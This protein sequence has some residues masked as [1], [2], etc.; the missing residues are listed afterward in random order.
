MSK[1]IIGA[2]DN[3]Q[4]GNLMD[5]INGAVELLGGWDKFVKPH[6]QVLLKV[7]MIGPKTADSAAVTHPEFV[8]AMIRI[9]KAKN[10]TVW[11]GD[12]SGGAIAGI[13]P[14]AK[15]FKVTGYEKVALEEGA[16]IKNFDTEGVVGVTP[17]SRCEET[18]YIAKP[19]FDADVVI[20]LAKLKTHSAQIFT[21]AVKNVFGCIPGLR[22]ARYHKMAPDPGEFGHIICDIHRA[23][24]IKLHIMDGILAMQ[25]EGPTAGKVYQ[26]NKILASEDPLALDT[27]AAG[28]VGLDIETVPILTTARK[29]NLGESRLS[30]ITLAGDFKQVP[31]LRD[32]KLPKRARTGKRRSSKTIV[33]VI[34]FFNTRPQVNLHKCRK[35]NVCVESC[36]VQAI[37]KETKEINYHK[38][39]ECMCCHELCMYKAVDLKNRN[40]VAGLISGFL[41]R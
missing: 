3:Y 2:C 35:C 18:M 17:E 25:G 29:R 16:E 22:K 11:I 8:R 40:R 1:V 21:G 4:V 5:K 7:N 28:M 32:F 12:S 6:D 34:E 9:L 27:V 33:K 26:A 36:P 31:K 23:T 38:C 39:I 37:N 20:N 10:C 19:M 24:S 13:A 14:T 41:R 15:S 30:K